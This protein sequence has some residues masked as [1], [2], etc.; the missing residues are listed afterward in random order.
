MG[1][2]TPNSLERTEVSTFR[3]VAAFVGQT[4]VGAVTLSLVQYFGKGNARWAGSGQWG[5]LVF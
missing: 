4:I 1:V 5:V 2:I 3:F